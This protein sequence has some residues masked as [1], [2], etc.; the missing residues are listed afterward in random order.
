MM[1][2]IISI[3]AI[4]A[5]VSVYSVMAQAHPITPAASVKT[6]T[7]SDKVGKNQFEWN[8]TAPLETINGTTEGITGW[9]KFD[10]TKPTTITGTV[11]ANVATMKSGNDM[12]DNHIKS[13]K[14][15]DAEKYENITFTAKSVKNQSVNGAKVI[16]DVVGD[17]TMHGVTKQIVVPVEI[18]Y[19]KANEETAKRAPGDF[20]SLTATFTVSL[21]DFAVKGS[22]GTIGN[23][24]GE[25]ISITAKLFASDGQ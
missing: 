25:T 3:A 15:L 23:K 18:N 24:V 9:L 21:K 19:L 4:A 6:F 13:E 16:A 14:W 20:V 17:F 10:P 22:E 5:F 11:S 1:K 7:L 12:R 8:S 2:R